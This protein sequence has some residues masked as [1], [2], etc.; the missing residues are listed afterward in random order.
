MSFSGLL[1]STINCFWL[2]TRS[3]FNFLLHHSLREINRLILV[4]ACLRSFISASI[5]HRLLLLLVL[6]LVLLPQSFL[7][8]FIHGQAAAAPPVTQASLLPFRPP[9][10]LLLSAFPRP[11]SHPDTHTHTHP[12][13]ALPPCL[14]LPRSL[15]HSG[16]SCDFSEAEPYKP[17]ALGGLSVGTAL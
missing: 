3:E 8:R 6:V 15:P 11:T 10:L 14:S 17:A 7:R 13:L 4:D 12:S 9:C 16:K 5:H 1:P 2:V